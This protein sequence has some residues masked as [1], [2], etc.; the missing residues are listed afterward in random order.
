MVPFRFPA[1][2][3]QGEEYEDADRIRRCHALLSCTLRYQTTVLQAQ[4]RGGGCRGSASEASCRASGV[5]S[6]EEGWMRDSLME[7]QMHELLQQK[8]IVSSID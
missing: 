2:W 8:L 5:N 3:R 1:E 4:L 7:A 6:R